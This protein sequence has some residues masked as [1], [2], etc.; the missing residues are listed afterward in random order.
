M[1]IECGECERDLRG[2]HDPSCSRYM[3][4]F[5]VGVRYEADGYMTVRAKNAEDAK[6]IVRA[7]A[8]RVDYDRCDGNFEMMPTTPDMTITVEPEMVEADEDNS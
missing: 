8:V 5:Q 4:D 3:A 7:L 2:G 6:R 1:S